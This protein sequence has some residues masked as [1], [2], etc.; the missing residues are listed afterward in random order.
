MKKYFFIKLLV[1]CIFMVIA[2]MICDLTKYYVRPIYYSENEKRVVIN[3]KEVTRNLPD[4]VLFKNEKVM[5][6][7]DTI[8]KYFDEYIYFDEKYETI[9]VTNDK[10]VVKLK[11][12]ENKI[13]I[14]GN[15]KEIIASAYK[16]SDEIYV[17][18][19]ELQEIYDIEVVNNEKIIVTTNDKEYSKLNMNVKG[20]L[21]LHEKELSLT[22]GKFRKEDEITVFKIDEESGYAKVRTE[23]GDLGYIRCNRLDG[24]MLCEN[25]IQEQ[26]T[27]SEK[28]NLTWEYAENYTPNRNDERK[29]EGLD[30]ISPTWI[31]VKNINGEVRINT[32]STEY[33]SW[34]KNNGYKL[35]PILKNDDLDLEKTSQ[36]VT[37][38]YARE[39]LINNVIEVA[40]KY[41]FEGINLDFENM[42]MKDKNEFSQ[43]VRELSAALKR[44]GLISSVDVNVPDGSA[45]WSL[46]YDHKP[47][48]DACDYM[49]LMAYDQY[50]VS[51]DG[52]VASLAWVESNI[53]KLLE[54][55]KVEPTKLVLGVPFY[56]KYRKNKITVVDGEEQQT[57]MK[58]YT[59]SMKNAKNYLIN[60][61]YKEH[62]KWDEDL[63]QYYVE[64]RNKNEIEKVWIEDENALK[65]KVKL[66]NVYN[67]AGIA[68]W[69]W[70]YETDEAWTVINSTL[71]KK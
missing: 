68:S 34:A 63:G 8:Q 20:K 10:D 53:K 6:S 9:I 40:L 28:I 70:G 33:I 55:E 35:W 12:N 61:K 30:I 2:Y 46:C 36:L 19:E 51:Q 15:D 44:N 57:K 58:S 13:N 49:I 31:Y 56:S 26:V 66:V 41:D 71:N 25:K 37:D 43:F 62:V 24:I 11:L 65:E 39:T 32:I 69:R 42:Y 17:P 27:N 16:D 67:L 29:I 5:F 3:D 54:R 14:N 45:N 52:P 59:L 60:S 47:I 21:K 4:E 64:Y 48:S 1:I 7:F 38:M 18:I 23:N 50:G 22:T